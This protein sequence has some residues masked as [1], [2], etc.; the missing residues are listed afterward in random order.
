MYI[1]FSTRLHE[2][3]PRSGNNCKKFIRGK[4]KQ[5]RKGLTSDYFTQFVFRVKGKTNKF[6][7]HE[8]DKD[9]F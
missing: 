9:S 7:S 1:L 2:G 3:S 4:R 6:Y 8:N 5:D